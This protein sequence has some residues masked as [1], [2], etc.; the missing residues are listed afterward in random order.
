MVAALDVNQ[1][2]KSD[3]LIYPNTDDIPI[4]TKN[5]ELTQ[6]R[7]HKRRGSGGPRNSAGDPE[8]RRCQ[9]CTRQHTG[10]IEHAGMSAMG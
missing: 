2:N 5:D 6:K 9:G 8:H 3:V 1:A 7:H 4:L 10:V